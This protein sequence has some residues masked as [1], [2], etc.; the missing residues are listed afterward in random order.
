[1]AAPAGRAA[2]D[3]GARYLD[4]HAAWLEAI[5]TVPH[6]ATATCEPGEGEGIP[7]MPQH[8]HF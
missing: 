2:L 5:S 6:D 7:T 1:M 3:E 4:G 8:Y